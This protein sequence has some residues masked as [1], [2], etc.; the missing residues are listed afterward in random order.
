MIIYDRKENFGINYKKSIK[1]LR[2][3]WGLYEC[4]Y[5]GG[6]MANDGPTTLHILFKIIHPDTSIG[7]SNLKDEIE[8]AT[9][10]KFRNTV[11]YLIY[12]M[13]SNY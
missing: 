5:A 1:K 9:L 6:I 3:H 4:I 13:S 12:S 10:S 8:K 2:L 11:K 7:V